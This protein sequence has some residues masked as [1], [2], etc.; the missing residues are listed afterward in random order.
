[1]KNHFLARLLRWLG[2]YEIFSP[3]IDFVNWS[4]LRSAIITCDDA[5][6][7]VLFYPLGYIHCINIRLMTNYFCLFDGKRKKKGENRGSSLKTNVGKEWINTIWLDWTLPSDRR[8]GTNG[9]ISE[10]GC[11]RDRGRRRREVSIIKKVGF[12]SGIGRTQWGSI[13]AMNNLKVSSDCLSSC[14]LQV[15]YSLLMDREIQKYVEDVLPVMKDNRC[16]AG[17]GL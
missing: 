15:W 7:Q 6:D 12:T 8:Q 13:L 14:L 4:R 11:R 2:P 17:K 10:I 3:P 16:M 9:N 5:A 1:L